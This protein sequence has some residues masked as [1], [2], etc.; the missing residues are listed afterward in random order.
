MPNIDDVANEAQTMNFDNVREAINAEPPAE[1]APPET[2]PT[3]V[4]EAEQTLQLAEQ[5]TEAAQQSDSQLQEVLQQLQALQQQNETLQQAIQQQSQQQEE[6]IVE[7]IMEPPVLDVNS[8]MYDDEETAK[9][10]VN[11]FADSLTQFTE[12][13][14]LDKLAPYIEQSEQIKQQNAKSEAIKALSSVPELEGFSELLPQIE[15][16]VASNPLLKNTQNIEEAYINAYAIAKGVTAMNTPKTEPAEPTPEQIIGLLAKNPDAQKLYEQERLKKLEESQQV[17]P[18]NA[19]S[20]AFN[21]ALNIPKKP[22]DFSEVRKLL[23]GNQ[24]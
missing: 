10:K 3:P 6:K 9:S 7:E 18:L 8:L 21:A 12:K 20:G 16:I 13:N 11:Q 17:P 15:N 23:S 4:P 2:E 1:E 19:S 22:K 14:I 5:A 24:N